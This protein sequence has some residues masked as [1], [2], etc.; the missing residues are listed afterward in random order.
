M[1]LNEMPLQKYYY[2]IECNFIEKKEYL[3]R[4]AASPS[5]I[6]LAVLFAV[7]VREQM[8][9]GY[10]LGFPCKTE[11]SLS[12]DSVFHPPRMCP[13]L[14]HMGVSIEPRLFSH[15]QGTSFLAFTAIDKVMFC[16]RFVNRMKTISKLALHL[17]PNRNAEF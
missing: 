3:M 8:P 16:A 2:L 12:E 9:I 5:M 1:T 6:L 14:R 15:G 11:S 4:T 10:S 7:P 17:P 13:V